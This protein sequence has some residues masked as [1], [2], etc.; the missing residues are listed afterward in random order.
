MKPNSMMPSTTSSRS[1]SVSANSISSAPLSARSDRRTIDLNAAKLS[2]PALQKSELR[3][4]IEDR[5]FPR[6][7]PQAPGAHQ[8]PTSDITKAKCSTAPCE[9][10]HDQVQ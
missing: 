6:V 8:R 10:I 2:P 1:G 5:Y 7:T 9:D 3:T 4:P